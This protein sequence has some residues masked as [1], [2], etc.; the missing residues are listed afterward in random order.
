M[1][2]HCY[3]CV[4]CRAYPSCCGLPNKNVHPWP[5]RLITIFITKDSRSKENWFKSVIQLHNSPF[6]SHEHAKDI[7]Y[8]SRYLRWHPRKI[9]LSVL[10]IPEHY[11]IHFLYVSMS[12]FPVT[13]RYSYLLNYI[14]NSIVSIATGYGLH[15]QGVR[16]RVP[17]WARI[18]TSSCHPDRLRGPPNLLSN[19]YWG[20]F[21]LG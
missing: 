4:P 16:A 5:T 9:N 13:W 6:Y 17:V 12:G 7:K 1:T 20:L 11:A 21:P 10:N 8:T 18:F 19:G 15:D 3:K 14:R 2:S